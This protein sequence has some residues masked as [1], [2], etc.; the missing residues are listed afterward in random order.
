MEI[1]LAKSLKQVGRIK[2]NGSHFKN[3]EHCFSSVFVSLGQICAEP[4]AKCLSQLCAIF[5]S[6]IPSTQ[7]C[8]HSLSLSFGSEFQVIWVELEPESVVVCVESKSR[9]TKRES[10]SRWSHLSQSSSADGH[11]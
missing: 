10:M 5:Q 8:P 7:R 4:L 3:F 2:S 6:F 11:I 9:V 1:Y